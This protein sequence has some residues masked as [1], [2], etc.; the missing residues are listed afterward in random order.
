[1]LANERG[2]EDSVRDLLLPARTVATA[3]LS[4]KQV[5]NSGHFRLRKASFKN[6]HWF[7]LQTA[8]SNGANSQE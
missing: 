4:V 8:S 2:S 1:M 6:A 5:S 3:R 7:K